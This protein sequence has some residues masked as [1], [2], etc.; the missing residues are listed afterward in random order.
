MGLRVQSGDAGA[1]L[2]HYF[3]EGGDLPALLVCCP[4]IHTGRAHSRCSQ[5][6][7]N[8]DIFRLRLNETEE[9]ACGLLGLGEGQGGCGQS[10]DSPS[11]ALPMSFQGWSSTLSTLPEALA[12]TALVSHVM[13][14]FG[15]RRSPHTASHD[16][17]RLPE[18]P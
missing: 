12:E 9:V 10:P 17:T 5:L 4:N 15:H 16:E 1:W 2:D 8:E 6:F 13:P 18:D 14:I 7:A 11:S 3:S